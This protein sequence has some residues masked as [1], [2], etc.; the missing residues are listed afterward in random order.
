MRIENY[1]RIFG[2]F[3]STPTILITVGRHFLVHG[4]QQTNAFQDY[5]ETSIMVQ[6]NILSDELG[7][8]FTLIL[9]NNCIYTIS[10]SNMHLTLPDFTISYSTQNT[11]ISLII[12]MLIS[13]YITPLICRICLR[14][15]G[16]SWGIMRGHFWEI[17]ERIF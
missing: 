7:I 11:C 15:V 6:Y 9:T 5:I 4:D 2:L 1:S 10:L 12:S 8:H 14:I 17:L 13:P 3:V 16:K